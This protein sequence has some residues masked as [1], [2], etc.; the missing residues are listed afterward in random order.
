MICWVAHKTQ[1]SFC[2][3]LTVKEAA[4]KEEMVSKAAGRPEAL[5]HSLRGLSLQLTVP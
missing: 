4:V 3:V 5:L 1:E 2:L